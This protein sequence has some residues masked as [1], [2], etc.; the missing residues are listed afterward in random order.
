LRAI[1]GYKRSIRGF[2]I[3]CVRAADAVEIDGGIGGDKDID[4][5]N[6]F[7]ACVVAMN[8]AHHF[9]ARLRHVRNV[10]IGSAAIDKHQ[11]A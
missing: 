1:H 10:K 7:A 8:G 4:P 2:T 11:C 6:P 5:A 3:E 9:S